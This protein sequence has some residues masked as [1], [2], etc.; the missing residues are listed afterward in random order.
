MEFK[1]DPSC[2]ARPSAWSLTL[3]FI[4]LF[5]S[6]AGVSAQTAPLLGSAQSFAV[7]AGSTVTNTGSSS[8]TGD[9]GVSLGSS[10]SGFPSGGGA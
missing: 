1:R 2:S 10:V 5:L 3:G 4:T 9:R 6:P 7:L 8:I